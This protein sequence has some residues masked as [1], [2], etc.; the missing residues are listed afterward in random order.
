MAFSEN[1]KHFRTAAN[2]SQQ[3]LSNAAGV[4]TRMIQQ[5]ERGVSQPRF[6]V[7]EKI[8]S[9]LSISIEELL[10]TKEA[11]VGELGDAYGSRA[12]R[13]FLNTAEKFT[14]LMAGGDIPQEDKEAAFMMVMK[15][16]T[17]AK[18]KNQVFTPKKYRKPKNNDSETE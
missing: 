11:A 6:S 12:Q 17:I 8:A 9:A 14:A 3:D 16:Y 2:M 4:S 15:A 1:L 13:D 18:E 5:Y 10:D 7:A